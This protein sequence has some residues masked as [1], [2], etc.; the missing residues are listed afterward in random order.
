MEVYLA[1]G[2]ILPGV[3]LPGLILLGSHHDCYDDAVKDNN[4]PGTRVHL[5]EDCER[6][7]TYV[8]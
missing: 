7:G 5:C 6:R 4:P 8:C 2:L 3:V 1:S